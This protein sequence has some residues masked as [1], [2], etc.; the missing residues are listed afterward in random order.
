L[1]L[2][3]G[4][5][6]AIALRQVQS[7]GTENAV[8]RQR[9]KWTFRAPQHLRLTVP[10]VDELQLPKLDSDDMRRGEHPDRRVTSAMLEQIDE[11]VS[12]L[13]RQAPVGL[14]RAII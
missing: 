13:R 5:R 3:V 11:H 1:Q 8:A 4:P 14:R 6:I 9:I 12:F 7:L 2:R 10:D